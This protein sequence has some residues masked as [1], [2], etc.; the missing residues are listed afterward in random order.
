MDKNTFVRVSRLPTSGTCTNVCDMILRRNHLC[1]C[2]LSYC[3]VYVM[4]NSS[5]L[6]AVV[7]DG[8]CASVDSISTCAGYVVRSAL[9]LGMI[10]VLPDG[11]RDAHAD[12]AATCMP[13]GWVTVR[14]RFHVSR[15]RRCA[16]GAP[17]PPCRILASEQEDCSDLGDF[18]Y[19]Q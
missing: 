12:R 10:E 14:H 3:I 1:N 16:A 17:K 6:R 8:A 4:I 5:G 7:A 13:T 19:V 9:G 18:T 15:Y 11:S 2:G